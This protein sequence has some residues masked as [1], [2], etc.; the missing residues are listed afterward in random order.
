MQTTLAPSS[1]PYDEFINPLLFNFYWGRDHSTLTWA[2]EEGNT[3]FATG[4]TRALAAW[5]AVADITFQQIQRSP[6]VSFA[7]TSMDSNILGESGLSSVRI[8]NVLIGSSFTP[9]T[10]DFHVLLHEI[11]HALGL[12]HPET[13]Q[14]KPSGAGTFPAQYQN[15][16]WSLMNTS[17]ND[18]GPITSVY[19]YP[20]TPQWADILAIQYLYGANMSTNAGNTIYSFATHNAPQTIWD[21]G[22][23]DTIY[24]AGQ[25]AAVQI[26]LN[27]S[28]DAASN[29]GGSVFWLAY[30]S[31]IEAARGGSGGDTLTGNARDN[32]LYGNQGADTITGNAGNDYLRG[33]READSVSGGDGTDSVAGDLGN[34]F[35]YGN[36]GN[37]SL[38]GGRENDQLFG[39]D[40]SDSLWGDLGNDTLSGGSGADVFV[41]GA[42]SGVDVISDFQDGTDHLQISPTIFASAAAAVAAFSGGILD[43]GGGNSVTITGLAALDVSDVVIG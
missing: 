9:G 13:T 8:S 23:I 3:T 36:A 18:F 10:S 26:N 32:Q 34:D 33:G 25:T 22:G 43:L 17:I 37:D 21:A 4:I 12:A 28:G 29:V 41:F 35:V 2:D 1:T 42:T 14:D 31:T 15:I 20:I 6:D 11:G 16:D 39:G 40:G 27:E 19:D 5:S 24:A 7:F 38:R 30:G